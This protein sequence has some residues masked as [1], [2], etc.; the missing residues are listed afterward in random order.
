[1]YFQLFVFK[2]TIKGCSKQ[3]P[4]KE[5]SVEVIVHGQVFLWF[6]WLSTVGRM[7]EAM[8]EVIVDEYWFP[9]PPALPSPVRV[10]WGPERWK[11]WKKNVISAPQPHCWIWKYNT[12]GK[13][14][15]HTVSSISCLSYEAVSFTVFN[16][17][18]ISFNFFIQ[19]QSMTIEEALWTKM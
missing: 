1:M 8:F 9:P 6:W 13:S 10:R 14:Q 7:V 3:L 11:R 17:S 15:K 12:S 16:S 19:S 2:L 4:V 5:A 18:V